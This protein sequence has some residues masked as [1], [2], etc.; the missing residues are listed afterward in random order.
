MCTQ[1]VI[2]CVSVVGDGINGQESSSNILSAHNTPID[3]GEYEVES[4]SVGEKHICV[5][6]TEND[7]VNKSV[8]CWGMYVANERFVA[9]SIFATRS[10]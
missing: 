10:S 3:L 5:V 4:A 8:C 6:G 7:A 2:L 1:Y 9:L